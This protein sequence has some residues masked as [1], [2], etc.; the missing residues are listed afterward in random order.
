MQNSAEAHRILRQTVKRGMEARRTL[1]PSWLDLQNIAIEASKAAGHALLRRF[2]T[3]LRVMEKP[4]EGLVTNADFESERAAI[5]V[6][7]NS[8]PDFGI[9]TEES[10]P[11]K[12]KCP[13]RF[14]L[15]PL[16]GTTNFAHGFPT[17]CVSIA[18]EWDGEVVTG[19]IFHPVSGEMFTAIGEKAR[20]PTAAE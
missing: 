6:L 14:I 15:D 9:L 5:K 7:K 3:R 11:R 4:G 8:C 17:F 13:G 18:A 2:R 10:D 20:S 1:P 16:D 19:V 12:A